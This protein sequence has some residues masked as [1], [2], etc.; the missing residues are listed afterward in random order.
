MYGDYNDLINGGLSLLK[1][2]QINLK[3]IATDHYLTNSG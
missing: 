2:E 3:Y 1:N